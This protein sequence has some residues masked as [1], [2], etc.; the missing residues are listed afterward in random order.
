MPSERLLVRCAAR[1]RLVVEAVAVLQGA[2]VEVVLAW[3]Q[4]PLSQNLLRGAGGVEDAA[5]QGGSFLS[6]APLPASA[7]SSAGTRV[8]GALS[9]SGG[10]LSPTPAASGS[11]PS[12]AEGSGAEPAAS[13]AR[14][15]SPL[16]RISSFF[17]A[18]KSAAARSLSAGR[19][20]P[21][22]S[23]GAPQLQLSSLPL[24][25]LGADK[26]AALSALPPQVLL[27][28]SWS[29]RIILWA[30]AVQREQAQ[31]VADG[32]ERPILLTIQSVVEGL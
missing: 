25:T 27:P 26:A 28:L 17:S 20:A 14:A 21:R 16:A 8:G 4:V 30:Q 7:G 6:P 2:Q 9:P 1:G 5:L 29:D 32:S 31:S 12:P 3:A 18:A 24:S 23:G 22:G 19:G 15:V 11:I 13:P 10:G